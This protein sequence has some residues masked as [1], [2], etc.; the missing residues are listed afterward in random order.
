[1]RKFFVFSIV[2]SAFC[3]PIAQA[4]FGSGIVFDPTQSVHAVQ[5][6]MQ[7]SQLYTTTIQTTQNVIAAYNLA[8]RMA[9]APQS[10]YSGYGNMGR[11]VWTPV[12]TPANTYG[13]TQVWTTALTTGNSAFTGS[14][15]VS[16]SPAPRIS[17]YNML[18]SQGQQQLAAQGA[19]ADLGDTAN[20]TT[21]E[22]LGTSRTNAPQREADIANLEQASHSSDP[23]QQ[24]ELATLQRINQ[25]LLIQLRTQQEANEMTEAQSLQQMIGQKQQ[26]DAL[27]MA[28][29][30][31]DGYQANYNSQTAA[32][33]SASVARVFQY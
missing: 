3:A 4:Q 33:S 6:I 21:L 16:V 11:Q 8:Q 19:T 22:T 15:Q 30:A 9:T 7:A 25:A 27:K 13:N 23:T 28:F 24:T 26:Q 1:M 20:A 12:T 10:L 18:D 29:Q 17:G 5:Q 32:E 2:I 31:A 14:Q